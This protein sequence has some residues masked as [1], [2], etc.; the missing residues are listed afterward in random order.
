MLPTRC[1]PLRYFSTKV[2]NQQNELNTHPRP[3][4]NAAMLGRVPPKGLIY[5]Y[6]T[7]TRPPKYMY[8]CIAMTRNSD[9]P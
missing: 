7:F 8:L 5:D 6:D 2:Q 1:Y 4:P 3:S 9:Q